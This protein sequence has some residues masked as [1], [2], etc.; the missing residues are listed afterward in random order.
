MAVYMEFVVGDRSFRADPLE[1][2]SLTSLSSFAEDS[3]LVFDGHE[4]GRFV[5]ILRVR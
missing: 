5:L 2:S 1:G 4:R 3:I